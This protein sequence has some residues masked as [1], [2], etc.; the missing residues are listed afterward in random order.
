[1]PSDEEFRRVAEDLRGLARSLARDFRAAAD[2]V[3]RSAND[4]IRQERQ[5]YRDERR[6]QRRQGRHGWGPY[7]GPPMP[8]YQYGRNRNWQS[9][10]GTPPPPPGVPG[11][12]P[13]ATATATMP[14]PVPPPPR[15]HKVRKP[16]PP[17]RHRRDGSTLIGGLALVFGLAWLAAR[18]HVASPSAEA[19]FALALMIV[20]ATMVI[21]ARTDWA[22]SRRV[23][24][25]LAGG[26]L[27][28]AALS[29]SPSFGLPDGWNDV[30][31]GDQK[32]AFQQWDQVPPAFKGRIGTTELDFRTLPVPPPANMTVEIP[33]PIGEVHIMLP[34]GLRT[35]V[36][37]HLGAGEIEINGQSVDS[38]FRPRT[39]M[40]L[41]GSSPGPTLTL[42]ISGGP[43]SVRI[44]Q[45]VVPAPEPL[46]AT[47]T[48]PSTVA[49]PVGQR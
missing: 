14:A 6:D 34:A 18:M 13:S 16:P 5:Q 8:P 4:A 30:R 12:A 33:V 25:A 37:A 49:E 28:I 15:P 3:R 1:M 48:T 47:P 41:S 9:K 10:W 31:A 43:S 17:L 44:Q 32:L 29:S 7:V 23:W 11:G 22:L 45:D 46:G 39:H 2:D 20:G 35:I 27:V 42:R 36:D 24:P 21:T 19:I 40:I 26:I 38:G